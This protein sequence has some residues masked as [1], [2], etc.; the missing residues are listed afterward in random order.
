M[1]LLLLLGVVVAVSMITAWVF[2]GHWSFIEEEG[3]G[4]SIESLDG[5]S[6]ARLMLLYLNVM[7]IIGVPVLDARLAQSISG[8]LDR[9]DARPAGCPS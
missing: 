2:G 6:P 4:V 5:H 8:A 7:G 9:G 1:L 3:G